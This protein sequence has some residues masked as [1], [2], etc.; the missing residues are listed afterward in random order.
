MRPRT[1]DQTP[2]VSILLG[3]ALA[4]CSVTLGHKFPAESVPSI[5]VGTTN[6]QDLQALFGAPAF[7][8]T[9]RD[10]DFESTITGWGYGTSTASG[11]KGHE[12]HAE[13]VDGVV[14]GFLF[15]SSLEPDSTNFDLALADQLK[16]GRSTLADA[17][18]LLGS[19]DGR[20]KVPTNLLHDWFG[21]MKQVVPPKG[22]TQAIVYSY[23]DLVAQYEAALR[24]VKLLVL[25]A[26]PD[27]TIN[28]VRR[29]EGPR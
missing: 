11:N 9:L 2:F 4:A 20:L 19:P 22:A 3:L 21:P 18:R 14:N 7:R 17:E 13:T 26:G 25:F 6:E 1:Q 16:A 10:D 15:S 27:G 23:T 5:V 8:R 12:L 29:Y 28:A 24:H